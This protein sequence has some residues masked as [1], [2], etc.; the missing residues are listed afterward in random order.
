MKPSV[1]DVRLTSYNKDVYEPSDDSFALVDA[2]QQHD[3]TSFSPDVCLEVGCGS[4]YVICSVAKM[5]SQHGLRAQVLA[6]DISSAALEATQETLVAH[7]VA[8]VE[9]IQGDL[10]KPLIPRFQH[11]VDLLIFNPPYVPTP[12]DELTRTDIARAWAGGNRGRAII[13]KF[14]PQVKEVLSPRGFMYMVTVTDNR[15]EDILQL[16]SNDDIEGKVILERAAD[17]EALRILCCWRRHERDAEG[18]H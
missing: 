4:G 10:L 16:L 3:W 2:L 1:A 15:P 9:L 12:D 18:H 17:E 8:D 14:L 13:D 6:S 11:Q 5:L 7:G